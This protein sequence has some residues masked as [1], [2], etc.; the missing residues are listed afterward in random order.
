MVLLKIDKIPT[1]L[2]E[3]L[4]HLLKCFRQPHDWFLSR[5]LTCLSFGDETL[6]NSGKLVQRSNQLAGLWSF[7]VPI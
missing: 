4:T 1:S 2:E 5:V 3:F 6:V 7:R